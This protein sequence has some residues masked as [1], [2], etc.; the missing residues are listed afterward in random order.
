MFSDST[1]EN[2]TPPK[3]PTNDLL[4]DDNNNNV[5]IT[6]NDTE[7]TSTNNIVNDSVSS[8]DTHYLRCDEVITNTIQ[9]PT[10]TSN[11]VSTMSYSPP[12][13]PSSHLI[14][15]ASLLQPVPSSGNLATVSSV[16]VQGDE[17]VSGDEQLDEWEGEVFDPLVVFSS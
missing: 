14:A 5:A 12:P 4:I 16:C 7:S 15:S 1:K 13:S 6:T 3:M 9:P 11:I 8:L 2:R 17:E 10:L